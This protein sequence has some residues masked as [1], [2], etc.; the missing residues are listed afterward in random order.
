MSLEVGAT[1][2]L[3]NELS[4]PVLLVAPS[5]TGPEDLPVEIT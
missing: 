5:V 1:S 3:T 2:W 4:Y